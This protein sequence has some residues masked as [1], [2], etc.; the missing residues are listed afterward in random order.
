MNKKY[1]CFVVRDTISNKYLNV[2]KLYI[3]NFPHDPQ[4]YLTDDI[5]DATQYRNAPPVEKDV[6]IINDWQ[7]KHDIFCKKNNT[8]YNNMNLVID[9]VSCYIEI[10][11]PNIK[12]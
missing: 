3:D 9:E 10:N 11:N 8:K 2:N 5:C 12:E 1:T 7:I 4:S 6:E